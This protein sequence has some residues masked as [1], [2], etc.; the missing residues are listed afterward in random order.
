MTRNRES[1]SASSPPGLEN[2]VVQNTSGRD[3]LVGQ[4]EIHTHEVRKPPDTSRCGSETP[5]SPRDNA[6]DAEVKRGCNEDAHTED[7]KR[8][9]M[10]SP[11][12]GILL[13][14]SGQKGF[15]RSTCLALC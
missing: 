13:E 1:F 9:K 2:V 14:G 12:P 10:A 6:L 5:T 11:S 7:P 4:L 8:L 3:Q 15:C